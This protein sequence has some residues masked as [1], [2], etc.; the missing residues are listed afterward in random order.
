VNLIYKDLQE[1]AFCPL[2]YTLYIGFK[3]QKTTKNSE[4]SLKKVG[5]FL[6][7]MHTDAYVPLA[8]TSITSAYANGAQATYRTRILYF[9]LCLISVNQCSSVASQWKK[10]QNKRI[11]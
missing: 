5:F 4:K 11:P 2:S 6:T 7:Q 10:K 9:Y 1:Q 8:Q 3:K